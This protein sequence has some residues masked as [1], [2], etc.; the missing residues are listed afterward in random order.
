MD[1]VSSD[2][3]NSRDWAGLGLDGITQDNG[4]GLANW[5]CFIDVQACAVA[6]DLL[7]DRVPGT[8]PGQEPGGRHPVAD[9]ITAAWL[10]LYVV[11]YSVNFS[12]LGFPRRLVR[13]VVLAGNPKR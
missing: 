7:F 11:S 2:S 3:G 4:R 5:M 10:L 8:A 6:I 9:T 13:G 12:H 1:A